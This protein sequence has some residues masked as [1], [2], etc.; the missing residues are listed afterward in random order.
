MKPNGGIKLKKRAVLID[1]GGVYYTE[2]F[3]NGLYAIA[4]KYGQKEEEFYQTG[5]RCVFDTGYVLG[6]GTERQFWAALAERSGIDAD[7]TG[8]R[9][10]ILSAFRPRL[11]VVRAIA[12]VRDKVPVALLTDQTNWLYELDER[13][14]FLANF[15]AVINSYEEGFS[16]R[17][18]EVFRVAC[19]RMG[20]FPEDAV[21]FDDS[22]D[23]IRTGTD[24]GVLS[25]LS[26]EPGT[27]RNVLTELGMLDPGNGKQTA[28]PGEDPGED[29]ITQ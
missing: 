28:R 22:P 6:E 21:F 3:K 24:F 13:D 20:I 17:D 12:E 25:V 19:Q 9:S 4:R 23:N 18:P 29:M 7:L 1:L 5:H 11:E 10:L 8:E 26:E 27:V 16:K 14:H 2:G 15:D